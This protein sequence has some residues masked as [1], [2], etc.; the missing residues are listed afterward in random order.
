MDRARKTASSV[1][2]MAQGEVP[3]IEVRTSEPTGHLNIKTRP[4]IDRLTSPYAAMA[5]PEAV[6]V[7]YGQQGS[8]VKGGLSRVGVEESE[9]ADMQPAINCSFRLTG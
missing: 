6:L 3:S 8:R 1:S 4:M 5:V 7:A 9:T 2:H